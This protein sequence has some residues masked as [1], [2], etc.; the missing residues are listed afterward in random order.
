MKI[1]RL[2][3]NFILILIILSCMSYSNINAGL[4]NNGASFLQI[5]SGARQEAM[6]EA[7]TALAYNDLNLMH[8]NIGGLA[9]I[10]KMMMLVNY[11]KWIDDTYQ[12]AIGFALPALRG[13]WGFNFSYLNEGDLIELD[14]NFTQT[15]IT[16]Q[17]SDIAISLGYGSFL[18]IANKNFYF[19]SGLKII[20][21]NLAQESATA[22]GLNLGALL[23][24]KHLSLGI[25]VNN[26]GIT[27]LKFINEKESLPEVY[28]AGIGA[29]LDL[30]GKIKLNIDFDVSYIS[31]Q[32]LRYYSGAEI[33]I[34]NQFMLRGGY[35]IH[36]FDVN[37]WSVGMGLYIP[38]DWL[39]S[40]KTRLDYSFNPLDEFESSTH[41]ISLLFDFG[42]KIVFN[43]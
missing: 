7:F 39:A 18:K 12:G 35:K 33:M 23:W 36:D 10:S 37:R 26:F 38:M 27:Q 29:H 34:S 1:C 22:I 13:V 8:Y 42:R 25:A 21:Q 41:R 16:H 4:S 3:Y 24:L 5:N 40:S 43:L 31:G 6:G 15:G 14:R 17:S 30:T 32:D 28:R 11:H 20:R 9:S 19:G 2:K